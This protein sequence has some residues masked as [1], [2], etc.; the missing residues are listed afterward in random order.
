MKCHWNVSILTIYVWDW[1]TGG[2]AFLAIQVNLQVSCLLD[3]AG[4]LICVRVRTA[5]KLPQNLE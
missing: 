1:G 5:Q 3:K 2:L 4:N